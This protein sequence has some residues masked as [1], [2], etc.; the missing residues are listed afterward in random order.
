MLEATNAMTL[1]DSRE[2]TLTV[3]PEWGVPNVMAQGNSLDEILIQS[4]ETSHIPSNLG[5]EL[6]VQDPV[7]NMVIVNQV[8]NLS[9][10]NV[11]G[12]GQRMENPVR[13]E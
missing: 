5:K 7:S 1:A 13:I 10:V 9:L 8:K 4:E 12:V 3:V 2:I 6:N 11:P